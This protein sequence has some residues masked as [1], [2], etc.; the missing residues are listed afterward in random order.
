LAI[1]EQLLRPSLQFGGSF[2][3]ASYSF[4]ETGLSA[5]VIDIARK[6]SQVHVIR[7]ENIAPVFEFIEKNSTAVARP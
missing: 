2:S 5:V 3:S 4:S 7:S 6:K 1:L